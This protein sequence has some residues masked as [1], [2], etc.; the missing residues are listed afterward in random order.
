MLRSRIEVSRPKCRRLIA[1]STPENVFVDGEGFSGVGADVYDVTVMTEPGMMRSLD[2]REN[3]VEYCSARGWNDVKC[4]LRVRMIESFKG[5]DGGFG[6]C[7]MMR[8]AGENGYSEEVAAWHLRAQHDS[9][10]LRGTCEVAVEVKTSRASTLC[11]D[12]SKVQPR[13]CGRP[14]CESDSSEFC[15]SIDRTSSNCLITHIFKL[16]ISYRSLLS[17]ASNS[18]AL[19]LETKA[20]WATGGSVLCRANHSH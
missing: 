1:I 15:L 2:L 12:M 4:L 10:R 18:S 6:A 9:M 14:S 3:Q 17:A 13:N 7:G 11:S 5:S 8:A 19:Q 16:K 20:R